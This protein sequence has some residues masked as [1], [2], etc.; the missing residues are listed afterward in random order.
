MLLLVILFLPLVAALAV[1]LSGNKLAAKVALV[2]SVAEFAISLVAL[3]HVAHS[4]FEGLSYFHAWIANPNISFAI[5]CDGLS[6]LLVL[7]ATFLVPVIILSSFGTEQASARSLYALILLMQFAMIGV[8][9]ATDGLLFYIFW[10]L[11]LIPIYFIAL[12]WGQGRDKAF[13]QTAT[14]KF[15]VY[16]L[17]GSL[18]MLVAFIFLYSKAGSLSLQVLYGLSLSHTEQIFVALAFFFA[19]AVKIP[20][21]PFH[22]WQA[23]TYTEAPTMGTMLLSGIMLKMGL[24]G[25]LRWLLPVA[26]QGVQTLIPY[27]IVLAVI[28][29]V[30][31]SILAIQ[32]KNVKRLLAYSSFAHVGL[33]AAGIFSLTNE[34]MQGAVVQMLA[35]GVNV[36]GAFFA[37]EVILRR[38]G[39]LEIHQLGGIRSIAPRFATAFIIIV[40]ASVALPTTNAFIGEFLLLFG[41]FEYNTWLSIVAGLTIILGAVYM[42]KMYQYVM[43]GEKRATVSAFPDLTTSELAVFAI[44]ITAIFVC[45]VYPKPI[46][47]IA[48]P[49]LTEILKHTLG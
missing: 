6:L 36:V 8:F 32:Q 30:Y 41:V 43:L 4:Q 11:A 20:V 35:H 44:L 24:Y 37:G 45:G 42:L 26:P 3:H 49:A 34:G 18:F 5:T 12:L 48:Q 17:I 33:I 9:V 47:E 21:F 31:G 39:T 25:L 27:F 10:E 29:V 7:L 14:F 15:F 38:T 40:L 22:T 46:M 23:D 1:Y 19:F 28:G 16:T 13:I 2:A